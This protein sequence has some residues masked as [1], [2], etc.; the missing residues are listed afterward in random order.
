MAHNIGKTSLGLDAFAFRGDRADIW[1]HLGNQH[2]PDWTV[3]DWAKNSSLDWTAHKVQAYAQLG[4]GFPSGDAMSLVDDRYFIARGDNGYILA[5]QTVSKQYSIVQPR[6]ALDFLAQFVSADERFQIDTAMCLRHGEIIAVNAVFCDGD[7]TIAGD[8]HKARLLASTTFDGSGSTIGKGV[9]TRTVC[10]N[11]LDAGLAERGGPQLRIR[12]NTK[13]NKEQAGKQL[14]EIIKGFAKYKAMG[15]YMAAKQ[16]PE[17][18]VSRFFKM[19]LDIDPAAKRAEI[20][21]KKFNQFEELVGAYQIGTRQE[22]LKPGTAWSMLQA[23]TRYADHDK[24]VKA[25]GMSE[26]EARFVSA[27]FAGSGAAMK[28]AAVSYLDDMCDGE[29]LRAV[30]SRTASDGDVSSLLK[31]SFKS[32]FDK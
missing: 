27:N 9:V 13:F 15:D 3:D 20:S 4:P 26:T 31:T 21:T 29:L 1:H 28:A 11:T 7:L 18:D 19:T 24:T 32:S 8:K 2:Q 25:N 5:P 14:G 23:V 10:N 6:D 16:F 12:H 17:T 30:A 22:G